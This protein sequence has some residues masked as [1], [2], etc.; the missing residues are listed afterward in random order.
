VDQS[1]FLLGKQ[2]RSAREWFPVFQAIGSSGP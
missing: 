1:A 2:E